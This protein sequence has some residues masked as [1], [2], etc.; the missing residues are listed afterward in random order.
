MTRV[1]RVAAPLVLLGLGV[2]AF[3]VLYR[4]G[5]LAWLRV[6]WGDLPTWLAT[7]PPVDTIAALVRWAA[8]LAVGWLLLITAL[9]ALTRVISVTPG[10]IGRITPGLVRRVVDGAVTVGLSTLLTAAPVRALAVE[11]PVP[12]LISAAT[13]SPTTDVLPAGPAR[14]G[15]LESSEPPAGQAPDTD[16][17]DTIRT[18]TVVRG[19]NLWSIAADHL[20][21]SDG[22]SS[23]GAVR[24]YWRD[25][26][27]TNAANLR[28][29]DPDLIYPGEIIVLPVP[30]E[31][32]A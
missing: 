7:N 12:H 18:Y 19:D 23:R 1:R 16:T 17:G 28:S 20:E 15:W 31:F 30:R 11:P 4:L 24:R 32:G 8:L 22:D 2:G 29:G 10:A 14:V 13:E 9:Y 5:D 21:A 26:I 25:V 27:D 3:V 6:P